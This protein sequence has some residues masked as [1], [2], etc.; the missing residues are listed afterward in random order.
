MDESLH[1]R[2]DPRLVCSICGE[3]LPRDS[4][5]AHRNSTHPQVIRNTRRMAKI[6]F[7]VATPFTLVAVLVIGLGLSPVS[8][9]GIPLLAISIVALVAAMILAYAV[10]SGPLRVALSS[11]PF[12]CALCGERIPRR[13][14]SIH[15][16]TR[17]AG[18]IGYL[19]VVAVGTYLGTLVLIGMGTFVLLAL[20]EFYEITISPRSPNHYLEIFFIVIY[21]FAVLA[22]IAALGTWWINRSREYQA[23]TTAPGG[24]PG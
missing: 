11:E 7:G 14:L 21:A 4:L 13:E 10:S 18:D 16:S 8:F 1:A 24:P 2:K 5:E 17:H 12:R 19:H 22:S 9:A 23:R 6:V 20:I 15:V 3:L